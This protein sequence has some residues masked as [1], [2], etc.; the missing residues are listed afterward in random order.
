LTATPALRSPLTAWPAGL[1]ASTTKACDDLRARPRRDNRA[2]QRSRAGITAL[3]GR[4]SRRRYHPAGSQS[5]DR[6][7]G[8]ARCPR[9]RQCGQRSSPRAD[10]GSWRPPWFPAGM[11]TDNARPGGSGPPT[12]CV[13]RAG[14]VSRAA[15]G[16][17]QGASH[18]AP[19]R[20]SW[21]CPPDMPQTS[22]PPG[23]GPGTVAVRDSAR[24]RSLCLLDRPQ[25][26]ADPVIC[27]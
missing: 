5:A 8:R 1:P 20:G 18:G 26:G 17:R 7:G 13:L 10:E 14:P 15:P 27:L 24:L 22:D 12:L 2:P 25:A 23:T 21:R 4:S 3:L 19:V 16:W 11:G 9:Q 6:S